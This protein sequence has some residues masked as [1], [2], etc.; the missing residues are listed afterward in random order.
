MKRKTAGDINFPQCVFQ[1]SRVEKYSLLEHRK[2]RKTSGIQRET[3][4]TP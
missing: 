2:T 4:R 3:K 1:V